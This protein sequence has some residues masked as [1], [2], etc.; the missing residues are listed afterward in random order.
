LE[1]REKQE[2]KKAHEKQSNQ[3][4]TNSNDSLSQHTLLSDSTSIDE[5]KV[6]D[7]QQN[8]LSM[9]QASRVTTL[10]SI[11]ERKKEILQ[12]FNI[13]DLSEM[14]QQ[15]IATSKPKSDDKYT[16]SSDS[17]IDSVKYSNLNSLSMKSSSVKQFLDQNSQ[18]LNNMNK[19]QHSQSVYQNDYSILEAQMKRVLDPLSVCTTPSNNQPRFGLELFDSRGSETRDFTIEKMIS[20]H[21]SGS[22]TPTNSLM[23]KSQNNTSTDFTAFSSNDDSF[24]FN[25]KEPVS[26]N[27]TDSE[28]VDDDTESANEILMS[29]LNSRNLK[30]DK[31]NYSSHMVSYTDSLDSKRKIIQDQ[32]DLVRAQKEQ[33]LK[34]QQILSSNNFNCLNKISIAPKVCS[35]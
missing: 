5:Q 21:S 18:P 15:M 33:L 1:D 16:I 6:R 2:I 14:N 10:K 24:S 23:S 13:I 22:S 35:I 8:L 31:N 30:N 28:D 9:N 17:G 29:L 11:E 7:Y 12:K 4:L 34:S 25:N 20:A 26:K 32:L 19:Q 27:T 3:S